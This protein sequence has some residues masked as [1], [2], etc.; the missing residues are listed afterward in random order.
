MLVLV[1]EGQVV[2]DVTAEPPLLQ[3]APAVLVDDVLPLALVPEHAVV[4]HKVHAHVHLGAG[5]PEGAGAM[6][7]GALV[8]VRAHLRQEHMTSSGTAPPPAM[9]NAS[10]H[11]PSQR[12]WANQVAF[13][14][15]NRA[16]R[17]GDTR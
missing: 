11:T 2:D 4:L 8:V 17:Y 1:D 16:H 14:R 6:R 13:K 10:T 7:P 3:H 9:F 15:R 12:D 5:V